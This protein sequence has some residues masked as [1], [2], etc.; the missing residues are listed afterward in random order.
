MY[1]ISPTEYKQ[2]ER[3]HAP[4]VRV[5]NSFKLQI[6]TDQALRDFSRA[7]KQD[8][9]VVIRHALH[10]YLE[11]RGISPTQPLGVH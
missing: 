11:R 8:M 10:E 5:T 9:S 1:C 4:L 6:A 2:H 7:S 3:R